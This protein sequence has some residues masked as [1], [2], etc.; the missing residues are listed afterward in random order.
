[1]TVQVR[2]FAYIRYLVVVY[3]SG[4]HSICLRAARW[5]DDPP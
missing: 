2:W 3:V 5:L 4:R 1:M